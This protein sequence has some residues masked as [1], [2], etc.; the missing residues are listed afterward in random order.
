MA[1][2]YRAPEAKQLP[3]AWT[4]DRERFERRK[5]T[6][7]GQCKMMCE[8]SSVGWSQTLHEKF[9]I[10]PIRVQQKAVSLAAKKKERTLRT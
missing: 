10:L 9:F 1:E 3:W 2:D 8:V 4:K 6:V 5:E 7:S